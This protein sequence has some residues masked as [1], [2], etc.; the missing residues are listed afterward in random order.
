MPNTVAE[1]RISADEGMLD[2]CLDGHA[3]PRRR[4]PGVGD[5]RRGERVRGLDQPAGR[6]L[7]VRPSG[8][9]RAR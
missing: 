7:V 4:W 1:S 8:G 5:L 6:R 3:R 9:R 2:S